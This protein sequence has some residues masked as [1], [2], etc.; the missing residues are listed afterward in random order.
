LHLACSEFG[1]LSSEGRSKY[2]DGRNGW[3]GWPLGVDVE[4][5]AVA[6]VEARAFASAGEGD[7][8]R[9]AGRGLVDQDV[10]GVDGASL[11]S[12]AGG[13][14]AELGVPAGV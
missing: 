2:V 6:D 4:G 9:F 13:G 10:G 7:V 3:G 5:L 8:Q 14:V 11:G 1:G 12:G